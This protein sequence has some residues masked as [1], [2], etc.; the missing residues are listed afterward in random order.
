MTPVT[1]AL[2]R[3]WGSGFEAWCLLFGTGTAGA[4]PA[5]DLLS[6]EGDLELCWVTGFYHRPC[7]WGFCLYFALRW[8]LPL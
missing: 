7:L 4:R 5:S 3:R 2:V 8:G 6:Q 1:P